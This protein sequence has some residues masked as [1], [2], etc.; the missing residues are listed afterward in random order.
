MYIKTNEN[1]TESNKVFFNFKVYLIY[2]RKILPGSIVV[3]LT[4]NQV[5]LSLSLYL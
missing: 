1:I 4:T 5:G 2:F 3:F